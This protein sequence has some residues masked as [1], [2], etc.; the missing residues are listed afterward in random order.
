MVFKRNVTRQYSAGQG[1]TLQDRAGQYS[2]G[3]GRRGQYS[4]GQGRA[5]QNRTGQDRAGENREA[6]F[7]FHVEKV[8]SSINSLHFLFLTLHNWNCL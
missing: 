6:T 3:Q 5:L 4:T 1:R 8:E 2:T 7:R